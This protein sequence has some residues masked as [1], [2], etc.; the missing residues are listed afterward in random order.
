MLLAARI[1][2]DAQCHASFKKSR[3]IDAKTIVD[4]PLPHETTDYLQ[5]NA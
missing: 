5:N 1:A 4:A 3:Q 2:V